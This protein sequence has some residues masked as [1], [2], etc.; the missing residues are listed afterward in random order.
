M[1]AFVGARNGMCASLATADSAVT[2][3]GMPPIPSLG[4]GSDKWNKICT[5]AV[6]YQNGLKKPLN[7]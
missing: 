2:A 3:S 1:E 6:A 7:Q 5:F 4:L